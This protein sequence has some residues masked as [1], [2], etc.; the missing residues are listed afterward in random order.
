M[1]KKNLLSGRDKELLEMAEAYE[2]SK[3]EG[4]SIYM[5]AEDMA[6]LADWYAMRHQ[7]DRAQDVITYGLSMHP[8]NTSLLVQQ[9]YLY[10]ENS[11]RD[12]AKE[13]AG[14]IGED[15][16]EATILR[17]QILLEDG[18]EEQAEAL[19]DTLEDK[20]DIANIIEAAY[21]YI[22]LGYI[23]KAREWI[24]R[25]RT[26]YAD[27]E[28]YLALC[29]DYCLAQQHL[30]EAITYYN[31]LIDKNPYSPLYWYGIARCYYEQREYS[32]AIDA[33]DYATLSDE[34]FADAYLLR[35]NA[36]YE[37]KNDDK[38]L[39]NYRQAERLNLIPHGFV[40][41]FQG[42]MKSAK[43]EWQK[44]YEYFQQAIT[45]DD[46]LLD[47]D[48]RGSLLSSIALCLYKLGKKQQ[49]NEYWDTA[50]TLDPGAID[51]YL[52]EGQAYLESGDAGKAME[53]WERAARIKPTPLTWENISM[54]CLSINQPE[55][56]CKTLERARQMN[57][58][59]PFINEKL[60]IVYLIAGDAANF[61]KYNRLCQQPI[62]PEEVEKLLQQLRRADN[63]DLSDL[64]YRLLDSLH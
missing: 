50:K 48:S 9:A 12:K 25:G 24:E 1:N 55:Y 34:D 16:P 4:K 64:M 31:K 35:A 33:C 36:F 7:P 10:L 28:A 57:P 63:Q 13:T 54:H 8:A 2:Q 29:A 58:H 32:Q 15:T 17:A 49:A 42:M 41:A 18:E 60:A 53:C 56:A 52:V 27:D 61:D 11:E 19:L 38:A 39:E 59:Y 51:P 47:R 62:E 6:D 40:P 43:G 30:D 22:D 3:A 37:L 46:R 23:D 26:K 20:N 21:M 45:A 5:D 14:S 44:A